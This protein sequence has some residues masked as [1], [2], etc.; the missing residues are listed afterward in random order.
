MLSCLG[1]AM[2]SSVSARAQWPTPFEAYKGISFRMQC[3]FTCCSFVERQGLQ[4][5]HVLLWR[6]CSHSSPPLKHEQSVWKCSLLRCHRPGRTHSMRRLFL[7]PKRQIA[8]WIL[9][10][11]LFKLDTW[12]FGEL[13]NFPNTKIKCYFLHSRAFIHSCGS[14]MNESYNLCLTRSRGWPQSFQIRAL[15]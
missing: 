6:I 13:A 7:W 8:V 4:H 5:P 2:E 11:R 10:C 14:Y 12:E 3:I 9:M 15:Y 1:C